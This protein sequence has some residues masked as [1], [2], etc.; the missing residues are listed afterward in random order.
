MRFSRSDSTFQD[1]RGYVGVYYIW[2]KGKHI[3]VDECYEDWGG[4]GGCYEDVAASVEEEGS[5]GCPPCVV[6]LRCSLQYVA[7]ICIAR[8]DSKIKRKQ[9]TSLRER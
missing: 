6:A 8:L 2:A 1:D 7:Y 9:R 4:G 3:T 5:V